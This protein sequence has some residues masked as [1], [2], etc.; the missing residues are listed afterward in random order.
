MAILLFAGFISFSQLEIN[1]PYSRF[2]LG[3]ISRPVSAFNASM[4]GV[5]TSMTSTND[6]NTLNPAL[7]HRTNKV[8]FELG[9]SLNFNRSLQGSSVNNSSELEFNYVNLAFPVTPRY[10]LAV[11][12]RPYSSVSYKTEA[13][14]DVDNVLSIKNTYSGSGGI[15]M[16]NFANSYTV[17]NDSVKKSVLSIGFDASLLLGKISKNNLS[18]NLIDDESERDQI[19][20]KTLTSYIGGKFKLGASFRKELFEGKTYKSVPSCNDKTVKDTLLV[21]SLFYPNEIIKLKQLAY[22]T[23]F[24]IILPGYNKLKISSKIKSEGRRDLLYRIY[25]SFLRKGYGVFILPEAVGVDQ[26]R[27]KESYLNAVVD[28]KSGGKSTGIL[29]SDKMA[30]E[31]LRVESGVNLNA[32]L[33]YEFGT[34]LGVSGSTEIVRTELFS[35]TDVTTSVLDQFDG[36]TVRLPQAIHFG[37]SIDKENAVGRTYCNEKIKST[38]ALGADIALTNWS[39]YDGFNVAESFSNTVRVGLGGYFTPFK[40]VSST[41]SKVGLARLLL[42]TNYRAGIYY[43][44]LPYSVSGEQV[45]EIGTNI[46]FTLPTNRR[47]STMTW[48]LGYAR[49]GTDVV[50]NYFNIGLGLTVIDGSRWFKRYEVGL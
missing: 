19:D 41:D 46:G 6:I 49:R 18:V 38:W 44:S 33:A 29:V 27:L 4:G 2:G 45:S 25:S 17:L 11:G 31:Y 3:N 16:V 15:N 35:N 10:T 13:T 42:K 40:N 5:A 50:E 47:G 22:L 14:T 9:S 7:L 8:T 1:S 36:E 48:N 21:S 34:D 24:A 32:G 39:E 23:E 26:E 20:Q 30:K 12:L 37:L 43:Q 28:I